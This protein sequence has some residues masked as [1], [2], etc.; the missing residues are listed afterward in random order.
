VSTNPAGSEQA[1]RAAAATLVVLQGSSV[2][3]RNLLTPY[4]AAHEV[5]SLQRSLCAG[6]REERARLL[7][8][9]LTS[10]AL[11]L[12]DWRLG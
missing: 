3:L 10:I 12:D 5:N 11:D 2:D 1:I 8:T 4:A 6:T 7:S 9:I